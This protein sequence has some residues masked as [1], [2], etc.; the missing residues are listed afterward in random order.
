MPPGVPAVDAATQVVQNVEVRQGEL[1]PEVSCPHP[2]DKDRVGVDPHGRLGVGWLVESL[3]WVEV[4]LG[5]ELDLA[6]Q[7][8]VAT[9]SAAEVL[10]DTVL[11]CDSTGGSSRT[12]RP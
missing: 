3:G 1:L 12:L 4:G 10:L 2:L 8:Q 11:Q 5:L 7:L 6:S 9:P